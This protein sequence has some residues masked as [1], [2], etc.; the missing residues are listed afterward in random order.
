VSVTFDDPDTEA[1]A[2]AIDSGH[3]QRRK[4]GVSVEWAQRIERQLDLVHLKLDRLLGMTTNAPSVIEDERGTFSPGAGWLGQVPGQLDLDLDLDDDPD[5]MTA[6]DA[7]AA[8]REA[9]RRG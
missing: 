4:R 6:T 7:V 8:S 2:E 1:L 5:P 3:A 9:L